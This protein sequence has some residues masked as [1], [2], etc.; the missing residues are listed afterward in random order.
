M[1]PPAEFSP[2]WLVAPEPA[3]GVP[4]WVLY[5][6]HNEVVKLQQWCV[7]QTHFRR[8][9]TLRAAWLV[10]EV[11]GTVVPGGAVGL[12]GSFLTGL[13]TPN[14]DLDVVVV[15]PEPG[16]GAE[17]GP[18][19]R[20]PGD[21]DFTRLAC[22][23]REQPWA[24]SVI[25]ISGTT[26]PIIRLVVESPPW[27]GV[28]TPL[29]EVPLSD[30]G[31]LQRAGWF[32]PAAPIHIDVTFATPAHRGLD[33]TLYT[34]ASAAA[35]PLLSPLVLALKLLLSGQKL[36]STYT[37]GLSS[38]GALL[39]TQAFLR[40]EG[41][42]DGGV[43]GALEERGGGGAGA[44]SL[45]SEG[46]R[47]LGG[48]GGGAPA[49]IA[50]YTATIGPLLQPSGGG[51]GSFD[52]ATAPYAVLP[53]ELCGSL[54]AALWAPSPLPMSMRGPLFLPHHIARAAAPAAAP[55]PPLI[56]APPLALTSPRS[57][58]PPIALSPPRAA[59]PPLPPAPPPPAPLPTSTAAAPIFPLG[60]PFVAGGGGSGGAGG[61]AL[62]GGGIPR[63]LPPPYA[64][65]FLLR[66]LNFYGDVFPGAS[67][68]YIDS[69]AGR[70]APLPDSARASCS[71]NPLTISDPLLPQLNVSCHRFAEVQGALQ[72]AR[73]ALGDA[74]AAA[75]PSEGALAGLGE[76]L[77]ALARGVEGAGGA[78]P[79]GQ[80]GA[81]PWL[82]GRV[83]VD[84][85][86]AGL[87]EGGGVGGAGGDGDGGAPPHFP[88][89]SILIPSLRGL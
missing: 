44:P 51:G 49:A 80:V 11:V 35:M 5:Q 48:G 82:Q 79:G 83:A 75:A 34:R 22:V 66:L 65:F 72:M 84:A 61:A 17:A 8:R 38:F 63:P 45:F 60:L 32:D 71:Q 59:P 33:T 29:S 36:Q 64:G 19:A 67:T 88:L 6:L 31:R 43:C 47:L 28:H 39:I 4:R 21:L 77:R 81:L 24:V 57:G 15:V 89:L 26:L 69:A 10:G 41:A 85:G 68:H 74:V 52:V 42:E 16:G 3:T 46:L 20:C 70:V 54:P 40:Q 13:S 73:R 37:G 1:P 86:E 78:V 76:A 9:Q 30:M 27:E 87:A 14:S 23:L 55:A 62:I 7:A 12:Y 2:A 18:L 50:A 25:V 53:V 58:Q 56:P